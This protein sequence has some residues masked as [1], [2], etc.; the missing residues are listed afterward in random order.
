MES[1]DA[2][3]SNACLEISKYSFSSVEI[4]TML[5]AIDN[6]V[7]WCSVCAQYCLLAALKIYPGLIVKI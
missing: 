7:D 4:N 5:F 6:L 2:V 3:M 1:H